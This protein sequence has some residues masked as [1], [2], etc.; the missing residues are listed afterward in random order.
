MSEINNFEVI[1]DEPYNV[2]WA[3][4]AMKANQ[5]AR[6]G[7]FPSPEEHR[8][9]S[10][11]EYIAANRSL[12]MDN[13][14]KELIFKRLSAEEDAAEVSLSSCLTAFPPG[15]KQ[16]I[17]S[18]PFTI[19]GFTLDAARISAGDFL[20]RLTVREG[21]L[22]EGFL[23]NPGYFYDLLPKEIQEHCSFI[24]PPYTGQ[25]KRELIAHI[26]NISKLYFNC[27]QNLVTI[28]NKDKA[29]AA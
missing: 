11:D 13:F 21:G 2:L 17:V 29:A 14:S 15:S 3:D 24:V 1:N 18:I 28:L 25:T 16:C 8:A 7:K 19:N 22:T 10:L 20:K 6:N 12:G 9:V 27:Y 4:A 26:D 23:H 5:A